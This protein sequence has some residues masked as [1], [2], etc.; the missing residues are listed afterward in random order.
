MSEKFD[1]YS[2]LDRF[3]K[4]RK[5]TKWLS[6]LIG[7]GVIVCIFL[8][9]YL[10]FL[11]NDD[12]E[13]EDTTV[14]DDQST[15]EIQSADGESEETEQNTVDDTEQDDTSSGDIEQEPTE[16][17]EENNDDELESIETDD[18]LVIEAYTG[19]WAPV[20]TSQEE[21]H[22]ITWEQS[23]VDW[24]EMLEAG[25]LATGIA[26]D[27]MSYLWVSGDGP[28]SVIAT[29][30]NSDQ[31]EHYRVYISWIENQGWKPTKVEVLEENDQME[32][33]VSPEEGSEDGNADEESNE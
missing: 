8:F 33:M 5:N 24:Q 28:Q 2:R 3:E 32:K 17:I 23:S 21:P 1:A 10:V 22:V 15:D 31:T 7:L 13:Q 9:V 20:P 16:S 12:N 11:N 6:I 29:F 27:A 18:D 14:N 19:N 26:P 25:E 30:S 4:K